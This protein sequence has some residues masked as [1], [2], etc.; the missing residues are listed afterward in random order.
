[1]DPHADM[2]GC[3][4]PLL[5]FVDWTGDVALPHCC[6]WGVQWVVVVVERLQ[7]M[8]VVGTVMPWM[9]VVTVDGGG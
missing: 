5:S 7:D 1:M 9:G 3:S 4:C 2:A 8:V 6:C